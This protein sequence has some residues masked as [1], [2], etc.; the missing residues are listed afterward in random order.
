[1]YKR[2]RAIYEQRRPVIIVRNKLSSDETL[3][4]PLSG[5]DA[6]IVAFN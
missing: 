3:V 5:L 1:M 6:V 2:Y 4:E